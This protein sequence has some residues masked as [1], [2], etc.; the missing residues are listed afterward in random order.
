[1]T[2]KEIAT[3]T[4]KVITMHR[5]DAIYNKYYF[6]PKYLSEL[7]KLVPELQEGGI[8][9]QVTETETP[10]ATLIH[11][12]II[13]D[14][15]KLDLGT[16]KLDGETSSVVKKLST[17]DSLTQFIENVLGKE[18]PDDQS[19]GDLGDTGEDET[20]DINAG[21]KDVGYFS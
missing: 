13:K 5:E 17:I 4:E 15:H 2:P 21:P 12:S 6:N 19:S 7:Y 1:L 10:D 11:A 16:I 18:E 3:K 20:D 14:S 9:V 8:K